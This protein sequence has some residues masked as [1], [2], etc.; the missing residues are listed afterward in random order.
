MVYF[1]TC[2][3]HTGFE[4]DNLLASRQTALVT[5]NTFPPGGIQTL[6]SCDLKGMEAGHAGRLEC[7]S[8]VLPGIN[9]NIYPNCLH[10]S[11]DL[12]FCASCFETGSSQDTIIN[13]MRPYE[14][15]THNISS[16]DLMR[17]GGISSN[18]LPLIDQ[19]SHVTPVQ[20]SDFRQGSLANLGL[21]LHNSFVHLDNLSNISNFSPGYSSLANLYSPTGHLAR[22][23]S[24]PHVDRSLSG[25]SYSWTQA[26]SSGLFTSRCHGK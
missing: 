4:I 10:S 11:K 20:N 24:P 6:C 12:S 9:H 1:S 17:S 25:P 5:S 2:R 18:N 16:H 14:I 7:E 13:S 3:K 26:R 15:S 23:S 21:K 22:V 19:V 8:S